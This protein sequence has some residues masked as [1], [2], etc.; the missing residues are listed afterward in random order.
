MFNSII[1]KEMD[2]TD[3]KIMTFVTSL[4]A[5]CV[6]KQRGKEN[7]WTNAWL[8]RRD[9]KGT[10]NN[11]IAELRLEDKEHFRYYLRMNIPYIATFVVQYFG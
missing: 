8:R 2:D 4:M 9:E 5:V 7:I 11:I 10:Y 1:M 3:E 6:T